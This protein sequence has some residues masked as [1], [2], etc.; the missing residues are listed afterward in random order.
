MAREL[1]DLLIER[2]TRGLTPADEARL[3]SLRLG[4]PFGFERERREIEMSVAALDVC[5][6]DS[7]GEEMPRDLQQL[8][9]AQAALVVPALANRTVTPTSGSPSLPTR[10]KSVAKTLDFPTPVGETSESFDAF[11]DGVAQRSERTPEPDRLDPEADE[12]GHPEA[13]DHRRALTPWLVA[14]AAC[15]IAVLGWLPRFESEPQDPAGR[16]PSSPQSSSSQLVSGDPVD[17]SMATTLELSPSEDPLVT[18]AQG[19]IE[20]NAKSQKGVIRLSG[21]TANDPAEFQYQ[22]WIFDADRDDRYPVDGGVFDIPEGQL[23]VEIP[24]D[25]KLRVGQAVL[26]AITVEPRGGVVV[27][28]R[29]R[30]VLV[31]EA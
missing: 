5:L 30:I 19:Q 2:T 26:F 14:A 21:V 17:S 11:D 16:A 10:P 25:A 1:T 31:A 29:E 13:G 23:T 9:S 28:D 3:E 18:Q 7:A 12:A 24:I 27:S 22:L 6:S 4:D 15:V 8:V 20:W